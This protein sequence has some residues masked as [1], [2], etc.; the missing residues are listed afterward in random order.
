MLGSGHR[1]DQLAV[2]GDGVPAED[3]GRDEGGLLGGELGDGE[4]DGVRV[5]GRAVD[6]NF[7]FERVAG[8]EGCADE[9]LQDGVVGDLFF[10]ILLMALGYYFVGLW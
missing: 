1:E 8:L 4:T 9:V 3:G 5:H 2:D 7:V 6:E 10:L